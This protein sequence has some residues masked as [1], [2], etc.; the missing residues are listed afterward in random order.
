[1]TEIMSFDLI[2]YSFLIF[3]LK[4]SL[5]ANKSQL[6]ECYKYLKSCDFF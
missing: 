1:M 3:F 4:N 5:G 2:I 6:F